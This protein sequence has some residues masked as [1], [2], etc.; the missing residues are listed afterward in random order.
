[1]LLAGLGLVV[2]GG[3]EGEFAEEF[4]GGGVDDAD[5]EVVDE[6]DH[7][8]SGVGS[9]DADVVESAVVAQGDDA[10][11]VDAVAADPVVA[12]GPGAGRRGLRSGRVGDGRGAAVQGAV[13]PAV[14]VLVPEG[15]ELGLELGDG[16]RLVR[17]GGEPLLLGLVEAFD[18]AAGLGWF[19]DE[20][21]WTT[22]SRRSS[23]SK[24]FLP[25]RPPANR[26]VKTMPLSDR[27]LAGMPCA[28]IVAR[29]ALETAGPV[30]R[31]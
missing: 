3:V 9:S 13:R 11:V 14:V 19:G 15:V 24:A 12:V 16:G 29:N 8:G 5:V 17:L 28:A 25:P 22:C 4:A 27:T 7:V 23:F 18:L 20:F 26:V 30:T 2:P 1:L 10:G 21:F 31:G 6:P